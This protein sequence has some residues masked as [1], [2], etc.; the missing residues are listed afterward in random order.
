MDINIR[1]ATDKDFPAIFGLITELAEYEESLDKVSNSL[2]L[3]YKQKDYFN[4][5]VAET[6][7][8]EII[9]MALYYFS[10]YTWVGKTLYL[11]DLYVKEAYRGNGLGT[12]LMDKMFEVAKA[13]KCK[14]FRLQVLNWNESAIKLYEKSGFTVDKTWYNCDIEDL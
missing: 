3:M 1:K 7:E 8:K 13:E 9:G 6:E 10:Y 5:Y 14:R 4:C 2:E 11:D 12:R